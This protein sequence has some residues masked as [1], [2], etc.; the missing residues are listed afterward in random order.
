M[1]MSWLY[2]FITW[3]PSIFRR[4]C[5][6][7]CCRYHWD[8]QL[9]CWKFPLNHLGS[10]WKI[11]SKLWKNM[12]FS[13]LRKISKFENFDFSKWNLDILISWWISFIFWY[14]LMNYDLWHLNLTKK[15]KF[16][17]SVY[18]WLQNSYVNPMDL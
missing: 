12:K 11:G 3:N 17:F 8:L 10:W 15:S 14:V 2:E 18:S 4:S 7:K 9:S 5:V 13:T 6:K 1:K 16:N